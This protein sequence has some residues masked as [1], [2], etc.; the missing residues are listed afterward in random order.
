MKFPSNSIER[1]GCKLRLLAPLNKALGVTEDDVRAH[2]IAAEVAGFA[3]YAAFK[4]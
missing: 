3:M 1:T 2:D 4:H